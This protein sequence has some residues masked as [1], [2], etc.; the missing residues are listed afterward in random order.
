M[1]IL[2]T[3]TKSLELVLAGAITSNQLQF[4]ASYV[5]IS[6]ANWGLT[7]ADSNS[8]VSND[9]TAVTVAAAP[10]ADTS[11]QVKF[12]SVFNADTA[13]A[14]VTIQENNNATLRTVCKVTLPVGASLIYTDGEGFRVI[15]AAGAIFN[16]FDGAEH[17]NL[18][19]IQGGTSGEYYH[20]TAAELARVQANKRIAQNLTPVTTS[21]TTETDLQSLTIPANTFAANGD[22]VYLSA[23]FTFSGTIDDMTLRL[24]VDG[25][26][27]I[28]TLCG[29]APPLAL[30]ADL[31]ITRTDTGELK[32]WGA[33]PGESGGRRA[34]ESVYDVVSGLTFSNAIVIKFTGQSAGATDTM[35][36]QTM[37]AD[38]TK[39]A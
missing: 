30:H 22:T 13:A 5:D 38:F 7:G 8:G 25:V 15:S 29:N 14:T 23:G 2:N 11:R 27:E 1:I 20:L 24:Y 17:N 10:A 16:T 33:Q 9:T 6:Q 37:F 34:V 19:N 31:Y 4:V 39:A 18:A 26:A 28:T 3:T 35:T 21:G 12:L 36:Q 32:I